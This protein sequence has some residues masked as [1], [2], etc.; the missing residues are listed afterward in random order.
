MYNPGF[1]RLDSYTGVLYDE[2]YIT[3]NP[4]ELVKGFLENEIEEAK[5]ALVNPNKNYMESN[6]NA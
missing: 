5:Q 6:N 3:D 4:P 1:T 2:I